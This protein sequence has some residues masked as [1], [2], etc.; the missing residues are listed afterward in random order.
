MSTKETLSYPQGG[1]LWVFINWALGFR[2][3]GCEVSWLEVVPPEMSP[4]E[5]SVALR[6]LKELLTPFGLADAVLISRLSDDPSI[7]EDE[8][9]PFD[10][11]FDMRYD[12]P[13]RLRNRARRSALLDMD[14]G[15]LQIAIAC[16]EY[17]DPQHN[18]FFT[19]GSSG[20]PQARFPD[21]GK[22]WIY[23]PP[24]VYLPEWPSCAAP[25]GAAW[26]TV[27]HWWGSWMVDESGNHFPNGKRDG[28][29]PLMRVPTEV[30][31]RF[32]LAL[33]ETGEREW[34]EAHG[35]EVGDAHT[36]G[37]TPLE[38]RAFIQQSLGEF[39]AAKPSYVLLQT[40]W[41]S[42]RTVCYL[43]SGKPCVIENTGSLQALGLPRFDKGLHRFSGQ[44]DAVQALKCV[45]ADYEKEAIAARQIAEECFDAHKIC[46]RILT[47]TL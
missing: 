32:V 26:S 3:C 44:T 39:S 11:L 36:V 43:A 29:L 8:I 25:E 45:L 14:P 27:A 20:T 47:L 31:T 24:A 16:G 40:A 12:L 37:S 5:L 46:H 17:R 4:D 23:T 41:M 2:A 10:F 18:A 9:G 6:R 7:S 15:Q 35:F 22:H 1:H 38:Y 21:L 33:D 30:K 28:F 19:I 34:I 13:E 42:D